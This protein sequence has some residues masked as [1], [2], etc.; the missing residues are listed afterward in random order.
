MHPLEYCLINDLAG[1]LVK[2]LTLP[3][4]SCVLVKGNARV[5]K[6]RFSK[7]SILEPKIWGLVYGLRLKHETKTPG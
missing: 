7:L 1:L 2:I 6:T 4:H 3:S 5:V